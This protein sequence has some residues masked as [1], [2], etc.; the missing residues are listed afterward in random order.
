MGRLKQSLIQK[1]EEKNIQVFSPKNGHKINLQFRA[2]KI[3]KAVGTLAS[4]SPEEGMNLSGVLVM[5]DFQHHLMTVNDLNN[6]T[7]LTI[8]SVSQTLMVP[9]RANLQ[10]LKHHLTQMY[11]NLQETNDNN[12]FKVYDAVTVTPK[13]D[14]LVLLW[15][16]DPVNDMVADS[17]VAIAAQIQISPKSSPQ[18]IRHETVKTEQEN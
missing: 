12:S 8:A 18:P 5:K 6:F 14:H 9:F 11:E 2:E 3:A 1:Y 15:N 7:E 4:K 17:I 13:E 16:S 10:E